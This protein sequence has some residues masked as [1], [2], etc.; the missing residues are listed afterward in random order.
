MLHERASE[1]SHR[2]VEHLVLS[3]SATLIAVVIGVS[4]GMLALRSRHVRDTVLGFASIVQTVPSLA[5]LTFLLPFFGIGTK[6]A[7]IALTLYALLPIVRNTYSGL[8]EV[9]RAMLEMADALGMTRTQR[10]LWIEARFAIPFVLA[11]VRTAAVVSVGIATLSAFIGAG[12]LGV[13]INRGLALNNTDLVLFG[14][15]PAGLLALYLDG[16]LA[17]VEGF[18]KPLRNT[19][20]LLAQAVGLL[21]IGITSTAGLSTMSDSSGFVGDADAPRVVVGSKNFTEQLILGQ[22]VAVLLEERLGYRVERRLNLAG[23]AVC[24]EALTKGEIDLYVEY[25]GTALASVLQQ[26]PPRQPDEAWRMAKDEYAQ[27]FDLVWLPRLGFANTYALAVR[28]RDAQANGWTTVSDLARDADRLRAG[29]TSEFLE[30]DDGF[31]GLRRRYGLRFASVVDMDPGLMYDAARTGQVDVI[32]AFSTDGRIAAFDLF[33]LDD[34]LRFFPPYDA[35]IVARGEFLRGHPEARSLLEEL[36][37][38]LDEEAMRRLNHAVDGEG[39]API[40]V[41]REFLVARGLI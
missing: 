16:C 35:G 13:F 3:L 39:R 5:M 10:M 34:D 8:S 9:P 25:T 27:R 22:M 29:F 32:S 24:H 28:K 4:M 12:G 37:G 23:T 1:L 38:R 7:I 30:R 40:E 6:P 11:G 41:A 18:L 36:S 15:I 21:L 17:T 31:P 26:E 14:A 2:L 19:R 33:V 20:R